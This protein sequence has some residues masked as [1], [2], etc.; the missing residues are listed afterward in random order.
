MSPI[1][2]TSS[3]RSRSGLDCCRSRS[4][5]ASSTMDGCMGVRMSTERS[6]AVKAAQASD[7]DANG[8]VP[9]ALPTCS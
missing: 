9:R 1:I 4:M 6:A 5:E 7:S 2:Q 3:L 8:S